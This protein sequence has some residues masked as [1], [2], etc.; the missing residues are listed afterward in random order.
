MTAFLATLHKNLIRLLPAITAALLFVLSLLP[1]G[2]GPLALPALAL[3]AVV[4]W[5]AR[6][7]AFFPLGLVFILGLFL[8]LAQLTPLG[9]QALFFVA[10][11]VML[12]RKRRLGEQPFLWLWGAYGVIVLAEAVYLWLAVA[13]I[14]HTAL[15]FFTLL[16]RAIV[17]VASFP[18]IAR[19]L[20]HPAE[21]L[22]NAET[23]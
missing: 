13:I 14:E 23:P 15:P 8:D 6:A 3:M 17:S 16:L 9:S 18:L 10:A 12:G 20:F 7:P 19:L 21:R 22:I 1:W 4:Y 11:A 2:I 5:T